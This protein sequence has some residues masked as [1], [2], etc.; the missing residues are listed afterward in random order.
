MKA[1][2][3]HQYAIIQ[4]SKVFWIFTITDFP[5]WADSSEN[6]GATGTIT[7]IDITGITPVPQIGWTYTPG[8]NGTLGTFAP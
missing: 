4:N 6:P 7:V 5:E 3:N 2:P 1:Q 8:S